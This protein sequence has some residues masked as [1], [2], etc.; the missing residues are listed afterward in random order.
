MMSRHILIATDGSELAEKAVVTGLQLAKG[1]GAKVTALTVS[2]PWAFAQACHGAVP[3]P[4]DAFERAICETATRTRLKGLLSNRTWSA[5]R[6][7]SK[8][9]AAEG[10]LAIAKSRGCDL[11]VMASHGR[12]GLQRLLLGSQAVRVLSCSPMAV[13]VCK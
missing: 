5:R 10:I 3:V 4:F 6:C 1:L 2:E 7:T 13:L 12:R 8:A 11:I 9:S